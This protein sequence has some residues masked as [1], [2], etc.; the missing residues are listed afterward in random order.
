M[1]YINIIAFTFIL[2]MQY[3]C[4]DVLFEPIDKDSDVPGPVTN[5]LTTPTPGGVD[6]S[7]SLPVDL[8][9]LYVKATYQLA[10]GVE[11]AI[12]SSYNNRKIQITG[13][14]DTLQYNVT[15]KA[16]DRSGNESTPV[17][18]TFKPQTPPVISTF[19]TLKVVPDFGGVNLKWANPSEAP[20]A[21]MI[22]SKDS[23]G[24]D[25]LID[26]YYTS[27]KDGNYS[28]RGLDTVKVDIKIKIKDKWNN[29]SP[30]LEKEIVPIYETKL[31]NDNFR[32]LGLAYTSNVVDWQNTANL[33]DDNFQNNVFNSSDVPWN[34]SFSLGVG[35][36]V[37][38][39]VVWQYSWPFNNFGHYYYG[40]NVRFFKVYGSYSPNPSGVL[41][42]TWFELLDG[43]VIK[44]SGLPIA[45]GRENMSAEDYTIAHDLGH[46]YIVPLDKPAVKYIRFESIMGW[47]GS[48]N[49]LGTPSELQLYGDPR[50]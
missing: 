27:A 4:Q 18:V 9:L 36:R 41:D 17:N 16:V 23:M 13:F 10:D 48:P 34:V 24:D 1:K 20:L 37:S 2:F 29:Y 38:R 8:D 5:V 25:K 14:A 39:I 26:A 31:K 28:L 49:G 6:V 40:G 3:A 11:R 46:E 32:S 7:Y 22:F 19:N 47:D 35:A 44:K 43:E 50:F 45:M 21:L 30:V 33:W 12:T 42:D 15:L